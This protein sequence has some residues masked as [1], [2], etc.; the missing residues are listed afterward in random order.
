MGLSQQCKKILTFQDF[1]HMN[2]SMLKKRYTS[3]QDLDGI[4]DR[5]RLHSG[6]HTSLERNKEAR[7]E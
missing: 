7:Y 1:C 4:I 2:E 3:A 5:E 6:T